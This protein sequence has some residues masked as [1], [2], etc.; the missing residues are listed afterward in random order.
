MTLRKLLPLIILTVITIILL[1]YHPSGAASDNHVALVVDYGNGQVATRCVN[2][3]EEVITGY[4]VL[5]RSGLPIETD[6][7]TGGAAV[8]RINGQGCPPDD[9]FC[10]CRGGDDCI[11]WS[12]W[13]LNGGVWN[14]S[15]GGSGLYQVTDGAVEGWVWGLGSV[16]QASPPPVVS[17][18]DICSI[19][20]VGTA[21]STATSS[22]TA[23]PVILPTPL[24]TI[25]SPNVP[26]ATITVTAALTITPAASGDSFSQME[27]ATS[28]PSSAGQPAAT[29]TTPDSPFETA[30]APNNLAETGINFATPV[31][32]V[33][34][35]TAVAGTTDE[36]QSTSVSSAAS[37]MP[38]RLPSVTEPIGGM[39][40]NSVA[41]SMTS[42]L[43]G[44]DMTPVAVAV[45]GQETDSDDQLV[46]VVGDTSTDT[47]VD[48]LAYAGF[49]GLVL[50]LA[51][52]ALVIFRGRS[53]TRSEGENEH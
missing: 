40:E 11:Y 44:S 10:S 23:T 17:F 26:E 15:A 4:E 14:Y 32:N 50:L 41:Q 7:Q 38:S 47:S 9:C 2:F 51:A 45:I 46:E 21:T 19:A 49:A 25:G 27:T 5:E 3:A 22:R 29:V 13:H 30:I 16:T 48:W 36:F 39:V 18:A 35:I 43:A 20:Q 42:D 1:V 31:S 12:Y 28:I 37:P 52:L 24:P 33:T 53:G 8:C 34:D 6:F